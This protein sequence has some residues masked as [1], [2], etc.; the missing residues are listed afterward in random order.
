MKNS[1]NRIF[2]PRLLLFVCL[3]FISQGQ[4]ELDLFI[5]TGQS[6]AQGWMGEA[7]FYP[8]E[9]KELDDSILFNWTFVDNESSGRKWVTMQAQKGRF[10]K[11]HFG[12]EVSFAR[13]LK[14]AGVS[15]CCI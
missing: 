11:G 7:T 4:K 1:T 8:K 2:I 5:W 12:P 3:P 13:E 9:G 6:N 14:K 10:P 15:S